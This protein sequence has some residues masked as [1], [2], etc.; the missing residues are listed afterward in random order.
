[1]KGHLLLPLAVAVAAGCG[2]RSESTAAAGPINA[3]DIARHVQVLASDSFGGR[4]PSS[5]GE[6]KTVNYIR[7]QL[8]SIGLQPG[9]AG[10]FFQNVPLVEITGKPGVLSVE[11]RRQ[12]SGSRFVFKD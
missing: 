5:P 9:N 10:S 7:D 8:T 4:A 11:G 1:M 6:E 12:S 2:G 3:G